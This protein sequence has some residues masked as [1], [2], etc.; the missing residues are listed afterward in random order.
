[1]KK[2]LSAFLA[3]IM[4]ASVMSL[5]AFVSTATPQ[6]HTLDE[7]NVGIDVPY[8]SGT[9][10]FYTIDGRPQ[11][12]KSIEFKTSINRT[13][14][15]G[16]GILSLDG[17]ITEEEWGK[18]LLVLSGKNA[19]T[20]RGTEPSAENT[21]FWHKW[22]KTKPTNAENKSYTNIVESGNGLNM[23]LWMAWDE[24]YLYIAAFV[25][26]PDD[27]FATQAGADIWNGDTLQF[28]I[29]PDGPNSVAD[30]H[31][32]DPAQTG[33][34][35]KSMSYAGGWVNQGIV[36]ANIGASY[37]SDGGTWE[38]DLFDMAP[39]YNPEHKIQTDS[40]N[41][42]VK[43]E[44]GN[45]VYKTYW[46]GER[47]N[48]RRWWD[49][50]EDAAPEDVP[51]ANEIMNSAAGIGAFAA[52]NPNNISDDKS[53]PIIQTT[54]ELAIPWTLV[55]GS[56][57]EMVNVGNGEEN[58]EK[59]L[60]YVEPNPQAGDEYGIS[61]GL[62]NGDNGGTNYNSWL[63][64][65]S[66]IF[67]DQTDGV[68]FAT[69]GG[70]NSMVL[71]DAELGTI[72]WNGSAAHEHTFAEATCEVPETCTVCGYQRGFATG[73]YYE[74]SIVK[75]LSTTEDGIIK[76][77]CKWCGNTYTTTVE[78]GNENYYTVFTD[79][80]PA[81]SINEGQANGEWA[82]GWNYAYKI[83]MIDTREK[84]STYGKLVDDWSENPQYEFNEDGT[85]KRSLKSI[86]GK[87]VFDFSDHRAGTYF[88]TR[89]NRKSYSMKYQIQL[90]PDMSA[91]AD[92][93]SDI[94]VNGVY[95][96]FGGRQPAKS[97]Y[98]YGMNYA[99]GFFPNSVGSTVGKFKIMDAVGMV[100]KG[101]DQ[102][103]YY[104]TDEIDLGT[105]WHDV[106]F[107]FD[108]D[109]GACFFYLDG[110]CIM[111]A[112]EEGM[113]MPS[114]DQVPLMRRMDIAY[115]AKGLG[116]GETAAFLEDTYE[117]GD[118]KFTVTCDGEVI[119]SYAEGDTVDLPVPETIVELGA[120]YRFYTWLGAEINRSKFV[121]GSSAN[122]FTYTMVMP[123][124]DVVLTSDRVLICDVNLDGAITLLDIA[125]IKSL[126]AGGTIEDDKQTYAGDVNFDGLFTI[127]DLASIKAVLAGN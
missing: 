94:Y 109:V 84:S 24:D 89:T 122:G 6:T 45:Y 52:I 54:Y 47:I 117:W 103:V 7:H 116:Y 51:P 18:P 26:D 10:D 58:Y 44:N 99:A 43:D 127:S 93:P 28:I 73:H 22:E 91:F 48:W 108:E 95:N 119:G 111:G 32:Y 72:S 110:E 23:K 1:M 35:W 36:A 120:S 78:S 106:V 86:D 3:V 76:S 42:P 37:V 19:A 66:G 33:C 64:W 113:K 74:H 29:D 101:A 2:I 50:D 27:A 31:G 30:G 11:R 46:T 82:D 85:M 125:T 115:M 71:S 123:G 90:A 96:W 75:P 87:L 40:Q 92:E 126:L 8:F 17:T 70:S 114:G 38:P 77:T 105:D 65:G 98:S 62:L 21:Y 104:E 69:A 59:V 88:A 55:S 9:T 112:A 39:R 107:V 4:V 83:Q 34:P 100:I 57:Y 118:G 15:T 5:T 12:K 56:Y 67:H 13:Q 124:N 79:M 16:D 61:I 121:E 41:E 60:H 25:E 14:K 102:R 80:L 49:L 53:N 81:S 68:E 20:F 97:G 63:T